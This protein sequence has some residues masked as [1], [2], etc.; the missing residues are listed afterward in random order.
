MPEEAVARWRSNRCTGLVHAIVPAP[1]RRAATG[2]AGKKPRPTTRGDAVVVGDLASRAAELLSL[3]RL[4]GNRAVTLLMSTHDGN[5]HTPSIRLH[6]KTSG[7]YDGG[8]SQVLNQ[9]VRRDKGCDCPADSPCLTATGNLRIT[10]HVDVTIEMPEMP[11]GLSACQQG[12]V[13]EFLR[14]VLGPHEQEHA[15]LLRTYNGTTNRPF[16]VTACGRE[17]LDGDVNTTLQQMHDD[18]ANQRATDADAR[19]AAIDPFERDID[20]NC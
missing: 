5:G 6:G 9:R 16:K 11:G 14:N 20:L 15:R 3:Q 17:G 1:A 8:T 18:E 13:R 10:Y 7:T 19:S 12:R 4:A 2:A